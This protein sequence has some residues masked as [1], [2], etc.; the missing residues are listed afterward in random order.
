MKSQ[1]EWLESLE[2][3]AEEFDRTVSPRDK[4]K[5]MAWLEEGRTPSKRMK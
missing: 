5:L 1:K 3:K 2:R 4:R